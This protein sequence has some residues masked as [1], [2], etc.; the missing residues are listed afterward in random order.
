ME[1]NRVA[2]IGLGRMGSAIASRILH[3][4]FEVIAYDRCAAKVAS[5][6]SAGARPAAIPA[7]AAQEA[8]VVIVTMPDELACVDVLLDHG[9]VGETLRSG[10]YIIDAS[11]TATE[12]GVATAER[13]ARFGII[14]V[15]VCLVG[16][17]VHARLGELKVL[18]GCDDG[19]LAAV[20]PVLDA[21]AGHVVYVGRDGFL[22]DES[23]A[24]ASVLAMT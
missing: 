21:I 6:V 19:D 22:A 11:S 14:H 10:G 5:A 23:M 1:I 9:G 7:D 13:L 8:D 15:Q 12:F 17:P 3:S 20:R 16:E 18:A 4:G 24:G 2:V